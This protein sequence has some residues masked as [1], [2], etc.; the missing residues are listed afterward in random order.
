MG[1][2][3]PPIFKK[4]GAPKKKKKWAPDGR[5]H[6]NL[7]IVLHLLKYCKKRSKN[8]K[9]RSKSPIKKKWAHQKKKKNGRKNGREEKRPFFFNGRSQKKKKNGQS[10]FFENRFLGAQLLN[11][12]IHNV[13]VEVCWNM[14]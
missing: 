10:P 2:Q 9:K 4:M 6:K 14:I 11:K 1:A 13:Q 5:Q 12:P 8:C 3:K 7:K